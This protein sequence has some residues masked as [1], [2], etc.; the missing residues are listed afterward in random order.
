MLSKRHSEP[1]LSFEECPATLLGTLKVISE[2]TS[3]LVP[4]LGIFRKSTR[5]N[6]PGLL[7]RSSASLYEPFQ[8]V[9]SKK[10][11]T[12]SLSKFVSYRWVPQRVVARI[13]DPTAACWV[14]VARED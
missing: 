4:V 8:L 2:R 7:E 13:C 3:F 10:S 12:A 6:G 5:Q 9:S 11:G 14:S 1:G